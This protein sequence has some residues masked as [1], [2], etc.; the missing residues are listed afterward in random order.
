MKTELYKLFNKRANRALKKIAQQPLIKQFLDPVVIKFLLECA[1]GKNLEEKDLTNWLHAN[2]TVWGQIK[3]INWNRTFGGIGGNKGKD[4]ILLTT[5]PTAGRFNDSHESDLISVLQPSSGISK[6]NVFQI[7]TEDVKYKSENFP[8]DLSHDNFLLPMFNHF[9]TGKFHPEDIQL[10]ARDFIMKN[11]NKLNQ[12]RR[13]FETEPVE[14]GTGSDG[15]AFSIGS[16]KVL[17]IFRDEGAFRSSQATMERLWKQPEIAGT[18]AMVY[19]A[20]KLGD[21]GNEK[22][23]Y[24]IYYYIIEKMHPI[25]DVINVDLFK[26]L[27]VAIKNSAIKHKDVLFPLRKH[28]EEK[29]NI[30]IVAKYVKSLAKTITDELMNS[31]TKE[32]ISY[33]NQVSE[34]ELKSNWVDRLVEEILFHIVF[35]NTDLHMGNLGLTNNGEFRYFDP[36]FSKIPKDYI[37]VGESVPVNPFGET[38]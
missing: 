13:S 17:K 29:K 1:N 22:R 12:I 18:S 23:N 4:Y 25:L 24:P 16:D 14:L 30:D 21:F 28:I 33:V 11:K 32:V 38:A 20:G 8:K 10:F 26:Q 7:I 2:Y 31:D 3:G 37:N 34:I 6:I 5:E 15:S 36:S 35:S 9:F 19:D 27:L